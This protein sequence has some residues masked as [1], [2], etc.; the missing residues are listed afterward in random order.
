MKNTIF[1]I[2]AVTILLIM[3][4]C[5]GNDNPE[6]W[7]DVKLNNW[8]E[9]GDWLGGWQVRPDNSINRRFLAEAYYKN[10]D[11][12]E[13]AFAFLKENSLND[14]ELKRYDIDGDNL[15]ATVSEYLTKNDEDARFEDHRKYIDIQYVISGKEIMEVTPLSQKLEILEPYDSEKDIEFMTVRDYRSL[16][17]TPEKFFIFF[18][19]DIHR[20]G[21]KDGENAM[22]RKI[23]VKVKID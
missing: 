6:Q 20:P 12:W 22:V 19:D 8:F 14:L 10:K 9:K 21:M 17:A 15:Y 13:K 4:G 18:P 11:R 2:M 5:R 3:A 7:N 23:V 16:E 1:G